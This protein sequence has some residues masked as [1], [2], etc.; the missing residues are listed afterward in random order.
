MA[1][2]KAV[3]KNPFNFKIQ[4]GFNLYYILTHSIFMY[5]IFALGIF[6]LIS[7]L[8]SEPAEDATKST[9]YLAWSIAIMGIIFVPLY[10]FLNSYMV[11]RRQA[12]ESK[13]IIDYYEITKERIIKGDNSGAKKITLNWNNIDRVIEKEDVFYFFTTNDAAFIV[14]KEGAEGESALILRQLVFAN[15]KKKPKG[16][17]PFKIRVKSYKEEQKLLKKAKK[18]DSK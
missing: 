1:G 18:N 3:F 9:N 14:S 5:L 11:T 17:V 13:G 12:K 16:K 6:S 15:L 10:L 4:K 8:T 7:L 2:Q